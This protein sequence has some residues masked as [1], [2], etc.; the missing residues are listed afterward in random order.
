MKKLTLS[1]AV[2]LSVMAMASVTQAADYDVTGSYVSF[3]DGTSAA[4][5]GVTDLPQAL[6]AMLWSIDT[7]NGD[8]SG[9]IDVGSYAITTD[10]GFW[11]SASTSYNGV[12]HTFES[13]ASGTWTGTTLNASLGSFAIGSD[14][15]T[16]SVGTRGACTGGL[17][18]NFPLTVDSYDGLTLELVFSA[19]LSSFTGTVNAQTWITTP[20]IG[21]TTVSTSIYSFAGVASPVPVPA[22]AWL[23]GSALIGLAGMKRRK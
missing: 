13:G 19:D 17:C 3:D 15:A 9:T 18:N 20:I 2:A 23:F 7:L 16:D 14:D 4:S 11:G 22:A 21:G 12:A 6:N 10:A 5:G 1:T 8:F